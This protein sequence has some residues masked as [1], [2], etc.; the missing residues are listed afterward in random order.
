MIE[1][2]LFDQY[3][4]YNNVRL[5][6]NKLRNNQKMRILE[7]GANEHRNLEKFLPQ[8]DITYL[9]IQLPEHLKEHPSYIQGD[10]TDM[11]FA[12][13]SYDVVV[14]LDVFEHI[15]PDRRKMFVDELNRVSSRFF[16]IT[17]PFHS[18]SVVEAEDRI[19]ALYRGIFQEDFRWLKEHKEY[20]LPSHDDLLEQIKEMGIHF[21][22]FSHGHIETWEK[23]MGVHFLAAKNVGLIDYRKEIDKFYNEYLFEIDYT[24]NSYRNIIVGSKSIDV[25]ITKYIMNEQ[26][27][28]GECEQRLVKFNELI[29]T[30][31]ALLP[32]TSK[33]E[34]D[35]NRKDNV[36]VFYDSG[37]GYSEEDSYKWDKINNSEYYN[38][39][40][41]NE[42]SL[43]SI[44]IDP[45]HY[46]GCF[47]IGRVRINGEEVTEGVGGNYCSCFNGIY[48]FE[49]D[50]PNII[51]TFPEQ[52]LVK[53]ISFELTFLNFEIGSLIKLLKSEKLSLS[54]IYRNDFEEKKKL[55]ETMHSQITDLSSLVASN[56]EH[57]N[58]LTQKNI[59][60]EAE[61][62]E[63]SNKYREVSNK[64]EDS[65]VEMES[66]RAS[67][68]EV[69]KTLDQV[70]HSRSWK[71]VKFLKKLVGR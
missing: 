66:L 60:K 58:F 54:E 53:T 46:K 35:R 20:G 10:A 68:E 48:V 56:N 45:S 52:L 50:D 11:Q 25:Q 1:Y 39:D 64:Y 29:A 22:C 61:Y 49:K 24:D 44:R 32:I 31:N 7:V 55:L 34:M 12:D 30:F 51:I 62:K 2:T 43:S 14:A 16:I 17:A 71:V 18:S 15:P 36:Q 57:I 70:Y 69:Q 21:Y 42:L 4:R 67:Y 27:K 19:N 37:K 28:K 26:L 5:I 40:L 3:Q 59:D 41:V 38:I 9:D 13:D 47:E 6:V 8:D 23:M 65:K 33:R 63:V